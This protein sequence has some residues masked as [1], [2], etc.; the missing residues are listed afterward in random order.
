MGALLALP[1][2]W[3]VIG[4]LGSLAVMLISAFWSVDALSGELIK[5]FT[6]D[7]YKELMEQPT[8]T[9]TSPCGRSASPRPRP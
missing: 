6:F 5:G 8:S 1:I 3:L 7:N 9:R 4:Y 2:A